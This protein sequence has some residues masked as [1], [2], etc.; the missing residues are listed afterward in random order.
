VSARHPIESGLEGHYAG[1]VTRFASFVV[2]IVTL[3]LVFA[4]G[5]TVLEYVLTALLRH[6]VELRDD[7]IA[8]YI[9]FGAWAFLYFAYPLGLSGR[10]FGMALGGI[11][12]VRADGHELG[13]RRAVVRV[14]ALP[15]SFLLFCFGFILIVL[16]ADRR[17]LHDLIAGSA[18]VYA[19]DARAA[20]I[21]FLTR[22]DLPAPLAMSS[23]EASPVEARPPDTRP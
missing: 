8:T 4:I 22:R 20:R 15:L 10:T 3:A 6:T 11:R 14:L 9:A 19:W 12:V 21:R 23:A 2:D 18:V 5:G 7:P 1:I 17:A 16:R 13:T